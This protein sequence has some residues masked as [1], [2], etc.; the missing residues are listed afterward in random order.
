MRGASAPRCSACCM[1]WAR[2]LR[3]VLCAPERHMR[4]FRAPQPDLLCLPRSQG[5]SA[6]S[7]L[8]H[9][10]HTPEAHLAQ[11][12]VINSRVCG[13]AHIDGRSNI[14][15]TRTG[16][17][18]HER[19]KEE[20]TMQ[21]PAHH[22]CNTAE[23]GAAPADGRAAT[24]QEAPHYNQLSATLDKCH[25]RLR[26]PCILHPPCIHWHSSAARL[27]AGRQHHPQNYKY[28]GSPIARLFCTSTPTASF[29]SRS[30]PG[31][32]PAKLASLACSTRSCIPHHC[33]AAGIEEAPLRAPPI[34]AT[35][36][37]PP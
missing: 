18:A 17:G 1:K 31:D 37:E 6:S 30:W 11:L 35:T 9:R 34:S 33:P 15:Q 20:L 16:E 29:P 21:L 2:P 8:L 24:S 23:C 12:A 22:R 5:A 19:E 4:L 28:N 32:N 26:H 13:A 10:P 27:M 3:C 36:A 7:H 14:L 25:S